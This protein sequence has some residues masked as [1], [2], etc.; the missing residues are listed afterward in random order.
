MST[1]SCQYDPL[2]R[3]VAKTIL[4]ST[5]NYRYDGAN[6]VQELSGTTP[7][8]NLVAGGV[9]EYFQRTDSGGAATFLTDELGSTVALANSSGSNVAQYTYDPFDDFGNFNFGATGAALGL[10]D[11][12][13]LMG[14]GFKKFGQLTLQGDFEPW[15]GIPFLVYPYGNQW[16]KED[17]IKEGIR[18][19][20]NGCMHP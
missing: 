11:D 3:R 18:Y 10:S 20:K 17:W 16:D 12:T 7:T 8:A 1:Q 15:N 5:T 6:P 4:T 14:A 2:G 9:D 19:F 13:L